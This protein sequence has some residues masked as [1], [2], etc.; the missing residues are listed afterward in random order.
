MSKDKPRDF[1]DA[2]ETSDAPK[3]AE[4]PKVADA[5]KEKKKKVKEYVHTPGTT[6]L[7][8]YEGA[9]A[10]AQAEVNQA[11]SKLDAAKRELEAKKAEIE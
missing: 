7:N 2:L 6:H 5:P 9:V 1:R 11:N 4:A 3:V 8:A 10:E